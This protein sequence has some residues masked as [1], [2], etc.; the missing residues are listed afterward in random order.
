MVWRTVCYR[1]WS[2]CSGCQLGGSRR[3]GFGVGHLLWKV[4]YF[5]LSFWIE[6]FTV[7]SLL[8]CKSSTM[9]FQVYKIAPG[10]L[11]FSYLPAVRG[12]VIAQRLGSVPN[13][14]MCLCHDAWVLVSVLHL[15][16]VDPLSQARPVLEWNDEFYVSR[17][18]LQSCLCCVAR[19]HWHGRGDSCH[20]RH[21]TA[22]NGHGTTTPLWV[23]WIMYKTVT[24]C[25]F[26]AV[27]LNCVRSERSDPVALDSSSHHSEDLDEI[28]PRL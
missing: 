21:P 13:L 12:G 10:L 26:S 3:S 25:A 20:S 16:G 8:T 23:I 2:W 15:S 27:C 11:H 19:N 5:N 6:G 14:A 4:R 17:G 1:I 24:V 22:D 9:K 28:K 18:R 7:L